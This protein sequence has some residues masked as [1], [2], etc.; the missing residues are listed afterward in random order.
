M[1]NNFAARRPRP[2]LSSLRLGQTKIISAPNKMRQLVCGCGKGAVCP[3]PCQWHPREILGFARK[4]ALLGMT[5]A[6]NPD[7]Q[8]SNLRQYRVASLNSHVRLHLGSGWGMSAR[9]YPMTAIAAA[10]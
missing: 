5:A 8:E 4:S 6:S 3:F 2:Q 10:F 9:A 7:G 1:D